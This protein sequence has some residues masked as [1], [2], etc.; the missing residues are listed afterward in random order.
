MVNCGNWNLG[1]TNGPLPSLDVALVPTSTNR[2]GLQH[3]LQYIKGWN[4]MV[5]RC[6]FE[7]I[8]ANYVDRSVPSKV[9]KAV[10]KVWAFHRGV[11]EV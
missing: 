4:N 5:N 2:S 10:T 3:L 11:P 6:R 1:E 7:W 9:N 8:I